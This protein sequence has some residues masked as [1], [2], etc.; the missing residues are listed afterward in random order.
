MLSLKFWQSWYAVTGRYWLIVLIALDLLAIGVVVK[1]L[2][3]A[4]RQGLQWSELA[5]RGRMRSLLTFAV[6]W[7]ALIS[8]VMALLTSNLHDTALGYGVMTLALHSHDDSWTP[9]ILAVEHLR[10]HPDIPIYKELFFAESTKFQYPPSSL[11]FLDIPQRLTGVSWHAF[12]LGLKVLTLSCFPLMGV[13]IYLL[14]ETRENPAPKTTAWLSSPR[15]DIIS[16]VLC[17]ALVLGFYPITRSSVLGQIQTP[18]TV[19]ATA[20]LLCFGRDQKR[21]AGVLLGL[22]CAIKPQWIVIVAWA[23]LRREWRFAVAC[24]LTFATLILVAIYTYGTVHFVDYAN[25]LSFLSHHGES[26]HAN[27]SVNGLMNRLIHNGDNL[28]WQA[29]QFPPY[30]PPVYVVTI[31]CAAALLIASLLWRRSQTSTSIDLAIA[32][33]SLTLA[34]PIAWEHHYGILLP[35]LVLVAPAALDRQPFGRFSAA[36]LLVAFTLVSQ[37]F[38]ILTNYT[39][40]SL[41]NVSQSYLL[42]GAAMILVACYQVS[43]PRAT[44]MIQS[45]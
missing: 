18:M 39:A 3:Y 34:S 37:T 7:T 1:H 42:I 9:M 16:L 10:A 24:T 25:V 21:L 38:D 14:L 43:S 6:L 13:L 41:M 29:H 32:M 35:I 8:F 22:C 5:P 4:R 19:A 26:F 31:A 44:S 17:A 30:N 20:A 15:L 33:L 40:D 27:Q 36:Y 12:L 45:P 23:A 28:N 11:L 2:A